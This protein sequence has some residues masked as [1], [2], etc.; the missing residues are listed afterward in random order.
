MKL[1]FSPLCKLLALAAFYSLLICEGLRFV[2]DQGCTPDSYAYLESALAL[3]SGEG[4][5][6]HG[7]WNTLWPLGYSACI[8]FVHWLLP[9]SLLW[10]SKLVNLL[11]IYGLLYVLHR[12]YGNRAYV[13][14]S[15]LGYLTKM[16]IYTWSETLFI[17]IL[18][19]V[20]LQLY[21]H[22]TH[23]AAN[24]FAFLGLSYAAF[25]VRYMGGFVGVSLAIAT[26]YFQQNRLHLQAQWSL[27]MFSTLAVGYG[28]YFG[29]NL[30]QGDSLWGGARFVETEPLPALLGG[31]AQG[32]FNEFI[33]LRD[34]AVDD[35]LLW[36]SLLIELALFIYI[37]NVYSWKGTTFNLSRASIYL[38]VGGVYGLIITFLRLISPFDPLNYRLLAPTTLLGCLAALDWLSSPLQ[39]RYWEKVK[40]PVLLFFIMIPLTNLL[41]KELFKLRTLFQLIIPN[42]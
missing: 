39:A 18:V 35:P 24:S 37:F 17:V 23:E 21:R 5:Q 1:V 15:A 10:A 12:T 28:L 19:L 36:V 29:V 14:G 25:L 3:S 7:G 20:C 11:A 9:V 22:W 33:V 27:R 42:L 13:M 32:W 30:W 40:R 41:P 34:A 38:Y 31:I 4:Y 16:A 2:P 6:W 26:V 8:A